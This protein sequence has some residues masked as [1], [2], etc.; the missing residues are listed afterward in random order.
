MPD[1]SLPTSDTTTTLVIHPASTLV[2]APSGGA[3]VEHT[4]LLS[5]KHVALCM[6]AVRVLLGVLQ[7]SR[8]TSYCKLHGGRHMPLCRHTVMPGL[9]CSGMHLL[10][11]DY[12]AGLAQRAAEDAEALVSKPGLWKPRSCVQHV[13]QQETGVGQ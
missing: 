7:A 11:K 12:K 3:G 10:I 1:A 4:T 5:G 8:Q 9:P 6:P 13:W 2:A